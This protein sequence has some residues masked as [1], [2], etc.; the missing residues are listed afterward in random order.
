MFAWVSAVG[1]QIF[2]ISL[3]SS[4]LN[5]PK[6]LVF[7]SHVDGSLKFIAMTARKILKYSQLMP[8]R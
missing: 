4:E 5:T 1:S 7:K 3:D 6:N 8:A 2:G